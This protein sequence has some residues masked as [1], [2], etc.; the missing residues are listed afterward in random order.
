[1]LTSSRILSSFSVFSLL[2]LAA[3]DSKAVVET[4]NQ[5]PGAPVVSIGPNEP[6]TNDDL[7]AVVRTDAA[8]PE[9][10]TLAYAY[11]WFQ[12]G[13]PRADLTTDTVPAAETTKGE[14]WE[15]V[16]TA[17]DGELDG[18]SGTASATVLN[19]APEV[20]VAFAPEA[21]VTGDALVAVP[22]AIDADGDA[23]TFTYAWTLDSA[24]QA[25]AGN[26]IPADRTEHG[27]LWSA[28]VTPS[29]AD[30]AGTPVTAEVEIANSA[31]VVLAVAVVP[32]APFVT[33]AVVAVVEGYDADADAIGYTYTWYVDGT[34]VQSGA[35]ETLAGGSFAKHQRI[36]V[37]VLPNDGFVDGEMF[38]S[39]DAVAL[40]SAPS[41]T[42]A[43]I[44][45]AVADEASTLGCVPSGFMDADGDAEGWTYAWAVNGAEVAT[46]ST[47][48]GA[49][50][51]KSDVV[52]CA[53][54]PWDGEESGTAVASVALTVSNTAP[55]LASVTLSTYAPTENDT[56]TVSLGAASDADG[57]S[58]TFSYDWYVNGTVVSTSSALLSN[59]FAEGDT[60]YLV[61]KPYDG[62]S[63]GSPVTSGTAT[64]ANTAP[65]ISSVTL[66][67]STVYTNDTLTASVSA[68]DL[69]GDTLSYT[70]D[71]YVGGV[72]R[73]SAGS[74]TLSGATYF[75]KGQ[76]VYVVVTPND[77]SV[78]GTTGTS[79]TVTVSN[80]APTAPVVE[81]TPADAVEGDDLTCTVTTA[82]TDAD[83]D[84][85]TYA[86]AWDVDGVDYASAADSAYRSVVDGADVG[87]GEEWTCEV[88]ASDGTGS[89]SAGSDSVTVN[90]GFTD[91]TT[92]YGSLMVAITAG[93][94]SM[95]SATGA[96]DETPVHTVTLT[97]DF[98]IG[99]TELT[100][101]QYRAGM[102]TS[103]S[104]FS[105]CGTTCPVEQVSWTMAA[106]YANA[107]STAEGLSLCYTATGSDLATSL[108]GDPYACEGYRLPTEAE[109][110]YAAKAGG[111]YTYSGSN[112]VGGVAW[113]DTNSSSQT[114]AVAGKTANAFGLY[115]MS[116][117]VFECTND[118]YGAYS[119]GSAADPVGASSG[120]YRVFRGGGWSFDASYATVSRR[121]KASPGSAPYDIGFRLARSAP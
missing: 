26:T 68:T 108:G 31:P 49:S 24:P 53:A 121:A 86:F 81:V 83:G 3:C 45:P 77:G 27:Q 43:S 93:S 12:D 39:A 88:T 32:D 17:N 98:W 5:A 1:M 23:V 95:G 50:F 28:S 19:S 96:A 72:P 104:Y 36:G 82:A 101:A 76:D 103:P 111:S 54:T 113:Y 99:E 38:L 21:P 75:D 13:V 20:T 66:T 59:R 51:D 112:T 97:H 90:G 33:D 37:E 107:L 57:D 91:Y 35:S 89:G 74:A 6:Q 102:G 79:S 106:V 100:Q 94:F 4:E 34:Q 71:W 44:D 40:N 117:N 9:G 70:Y 58:I 119:S 80:T 18:A 116:G 120:S 55:E 29:D 30:G 15:L 110:E 87:D 63:F 84:A 109:W 56:V 73:G 105:S 10:D 118:W 11:S 7:V 48:D 41:A 114:H 14:V 69:D 22:T 65:T 52:T 8:D 62:D 46:T 16:V 78:D 2:A 85:M 47:L 60:I 64:G 115:D 92:T 25:D 42:G 67:P 61:V